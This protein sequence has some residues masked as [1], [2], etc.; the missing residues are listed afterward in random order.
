[1]IES[2][3]VFGKNQEIENSNWKIKNG[4]WS[5]QKEYL[6]DL[7][8]KID[9]LKFATRKKKKKKIYQKFFERREKFKTLC[10]RWLSCK[11]HK[12]KLK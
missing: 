2:R 9:N 3:F 7:C 5:Q 4:N 12:I 8:L 11:L 10:V 1:M 6:N